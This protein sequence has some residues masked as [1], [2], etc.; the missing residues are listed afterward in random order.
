MKRLIV[1]FNY[2]NLVKRSREGLG[3]FRFFQNIGFDFSM[4]RI[5]TFMYLKIKQKVVKRAHKLLASARQS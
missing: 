5:D 4:P 3:T 2:S 1:P